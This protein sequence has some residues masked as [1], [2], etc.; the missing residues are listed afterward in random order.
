MNN[1]HTHIAER[2]QLNR[3]LNILL[4]S[5]EYPPNVVGGLSR[6]VYGLSAQLA[7]M[8]HHVHVITAGNGSLPAFETIKGVNVHRVIPLNQSDPHFLTWIAGLNLAMSFKVKTLSSKV[9]FDIVHAHDWLVGSA[10]ITIKELLS[11]PLLTTIHATEHGRNNGIHNQMQQFIHEKEMQIIHQSDQIIVCSEYMR[12]EI[13][14]LFHSDIKKVAVIPNGILQSEQTHNNEEIF[15]F[16]QNRKFI[17]SLGR[18]VKEK[19]FETI[20]EAAALAKQMGKDI[21]FVVAGKGPMLEKYRKLVTDLNLDHY[22]T[23]IGYVNDEERSALLDKSELAVFPSLYEPFGIVALEALL[24]AKP[25]IVSNTGGLKGLVKHLQ[26]G[27]LMIPGDPKSLLENI[28]LLL[29]NPEKAFEMGKKGQQIV[30][31]LYG[32]KRIASQTVQV[33][34]DTLLLEKT[35]TN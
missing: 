20:I 3:Q 22:V 30:K 17:F 26:S 10:A 33:I 34:E 31:S 8:G 12:E 14:S 1:V 32:W 28:E 2:S 5:W 19:G 15:P 4:L 27:L 16:I 29:Q 21:Y 25:T 7:E 24:R 23:F 9:K 11:I 13:M 18:I 35:K 6:H